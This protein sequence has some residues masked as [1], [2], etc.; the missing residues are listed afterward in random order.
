MQLKTALREVSPWV[1]QPMFHSAYFITTE[2]T[3]KRLNLPAAEHTAQTKPTCSK[4][5]I[6]APFARK[7]I[8]VF[9]SQA[10]TNYARFNR[11]CSGTD[12]SQ[13]AQTSCCFCTTTA[14]PL[15]L[16]PHSEC[17]SCNND[18]ACRK[19][20]KGSLF[21]LPRLRLDLR[22]RCVCD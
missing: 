21:S 22:A 12:S 20:K 13:L 5:K 2:P 4:T 16:P 3:G 1:H 19:S 17:V 10:L 18:D 6:N 14:T 11:Y 15:F 9:V 8:S 7:I